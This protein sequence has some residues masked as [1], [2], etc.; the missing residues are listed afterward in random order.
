[1]IHAYFKIKEVYVTIIKIM[2]RNLRIPNLPYEG[3][4]S[5]PTPF[6]TWALD[7]YQRA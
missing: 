3:I 4:L 2:Y 6:H 7:A 5:F 1:M